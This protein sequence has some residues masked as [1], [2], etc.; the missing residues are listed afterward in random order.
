MSK[1]LTPLEIA[2]GIQENYI[3]LTVATA[4]RYIAEDCVVY[5]ATSLPFGGQWR[6]PEGFVELMRAIQA[7]FANFRF[8]P[9]ALVTDHK[10]QLA[11]RGRVSGDTPHGR[12]DIP[13]VEYWTC[14]QG[15][16]TEAYAMWSDT[17]LVMDIY[18][19][20]GFADQ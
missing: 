12:F 9:A 16:V 17:K 1:I 11:F 18:H 13:F 5:E 4:R 20:V 3:G 7:T 19:G 15:K 10:E 8:T 2:T 6:G 14:R